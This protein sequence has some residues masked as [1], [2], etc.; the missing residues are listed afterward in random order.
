MV[1]GGKTTLTSL[2]DQIHAR[3]RE[4][5]SLTTDVKAR[6]A[7]FRSGDIRHSQASIDTICEQL[8]YEPVIDF[9]SGLDETVEAFCS[10]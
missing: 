2:Y 1:L 5:G 9:A 3:L 8:G 10:Q 4:R 6:Y 7:D